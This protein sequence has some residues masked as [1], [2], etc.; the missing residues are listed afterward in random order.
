M[1][2]SLTPILENYLKQKVK[3]GMYHSTSEVVREAL[4]LLE[5]QDAMRSMKLNTL[6]NDIQA[7]IRSLDNGEGIEFNPEEI[8]TEARRRWENR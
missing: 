7:G 8:K 4:R 6:R 1:N 2:I 3:S 5:N